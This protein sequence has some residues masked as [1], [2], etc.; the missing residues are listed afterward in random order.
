MHS[1]VRATGLEYA[2]RRSMGSEAQYKSVG[3]TIAAKYRSDDA[4]CQAVA[5]NTQAKCIKDAKA[6][7]RQT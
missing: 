6:L 4:A 3:E 5:G 7:H 1:W 2:A